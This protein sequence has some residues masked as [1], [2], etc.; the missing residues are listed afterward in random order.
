MEGWHQVSPQH[1]Q[2]M[3]LV[4]A[5]PMCYLMP[6]AGTCS[7]PYADHVRPDEAPPEVPEVTAS[8]YAPEKCQEERAGNEGEDEV[9]YII[10]EAYGNPGSWHPVEDSLYVRCTKLIT[11]E[12]CYVEKGDGDYTLWGTAHDLESVLHDVSY[13][14]I[15][16]D[17][18][19]MEAKVIDAKQGTKSLSGLKI[20]LR[21]LRVYPN[22]IGYVIFGDGACCLLEAAWKDVNKKSTKE[23]LED[24]LIK[25]ILRRRRH[26][27]TF[28]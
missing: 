7:S 14:F 22:L 2:P 4:P 25:A 28:W 6:A 15:R 11:L 20:A 16:L 23:E 9:Y 5:M 24:D 18:S 17:L 1:V 21:E 27:I 10:S 19:E 8:G 3:V 26:P 13:G 12:K